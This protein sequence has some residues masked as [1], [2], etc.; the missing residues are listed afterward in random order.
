MKKLNLLII[1]LLFA[2][3]S[4]VRGQVVM[5]DSKIRLGFGLAGFT[6]NSVNE[7]INSFDDLAREMYPETGFAPP[8]FKKHLFYSLEYEKDISQQF[9]YMFTFEIHNDQISNSDVITFENTDNNA[10]SQL[11]DFSLNY[12]SAGVAVAYY[13]P[14]FKTKFGDIRL[15]TALGI[16]FLYTNIDIYHFYH[17]VIRGGP[18]VIDYNATA[19]NVSGKG[20]FG[21]EVPFSHAIFIQVRGG[22]AL[23]EAMDFSGEIQ[24]NKQQPFHPSIVDK[25]TYN[26][27]GFWGNLGI[28]FYF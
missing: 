26:L 23:R 25:N 16:D 9:S 4:I 27:S 5:R 7:I 24:S 17:D 1:L 13:Y 6:S 19:Y 18:Q 21:A 20:F 14:V 22:F 2:T 11:L 10:V 8:L 12:M 3:T 15:F 28:A